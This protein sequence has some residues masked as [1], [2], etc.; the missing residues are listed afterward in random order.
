MN[1]LGLDYKAGALALVITSL[2]L[3]LL[4]PYAAKLNLLDHPKGRKDH[5]NPTPVTGG[6]AILMGCVVA[7]AFT[8]S[9]T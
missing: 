3:Y 9:E 2:A 7:F 4:Q 1:L 6:L 8:Q 5:A